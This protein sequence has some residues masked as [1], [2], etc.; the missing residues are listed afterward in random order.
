MNDFIYLYKI[1]LLPFVIL[2]S[3]CCR[4]SQLL[5]FLVCKCLKWLRLINTLNIHLFVKLWKDEW[6]HILTRNATFGMDNYVIWL[7]KYNNK[8]KRTLKH[9][10]RYGLGVRAWLVC[11]HM[12]LCIKA[13]KT[14]YKGMVRHM[15]SIW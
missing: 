13:L 6:F 3:L 4:I 8:Y 7:N 5:K 9:I 11:Y 10:L 14:Q 15:H 1:T 12:L 2:T